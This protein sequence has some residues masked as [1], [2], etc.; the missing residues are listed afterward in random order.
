MVTYIEMIQVKRLEKVKLKISHIL[1]CFEELFEFGDLD[2]L[3][4]EYDLTL[5]NC[6]DASENVASL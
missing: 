2:S 6:G 1:L 4:D 3:F 5:D